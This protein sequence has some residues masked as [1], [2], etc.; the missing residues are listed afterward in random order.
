M[1]LSFEITGVQPDPHALVPVL[2][3]GLRV[4]AGDGVR[5]QSLQ[6]ACQVRV[7]PDRRRYGHDAEALLRDLFGTPD[8]WGETLKPFLLTHATV[9]VGRF[10]TTTDVALA[11]ELSYDLE[12]AAGKY[13]HALDDG[14]VPLLFLFSGSV[15]LRTDQGTQV[16]QVPWDVEARYRLPV[17]VWDEL[18]DLHF[19]NSGWLRLERDTLDALQRH[20]AAHALATWDH[21]IQDLLVDREATT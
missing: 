13:L 21:V 19:P 14:D 11:V 12:V 10:T 6:L 5:V 20:K 4:G 15:F 3:F 18:M 17:R 8:R 16:Q 9:A 7:E 1:D 2:E